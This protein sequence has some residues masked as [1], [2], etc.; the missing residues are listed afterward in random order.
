MRALIEQMRVCPACG[1]NDWEKPCAY[2][3]EGKKGCL[4]DEKRGRR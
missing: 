4:R 1:G 3:S 2:P